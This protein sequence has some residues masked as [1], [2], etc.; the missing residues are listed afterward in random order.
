MQK[1]FD[2]G[3][4]ARRASLYLVVFLV[5]LVLFFPIYWMFN[6]S[7]APSTELFVYPPRLIHPNATFDAYR[8]VLTERP[9]IQWIGN[10]LYVV[11]LV[12][13][14]GLGLSLFGGYSLSRF[15]HRALTFAGWFFLISRMLPTS[16]LVI[17][18]F[19]MMRQ[20]G[21]IN[22]LHSLVLAN[23]VFIV[24][25]SIW[26]LKGYFDSIPFE[27]EEAAWL[28]G[29]SR[30]GALLRITLPLAA[31]GMAAT[32]LYG[33]IL[34]YSEYIFA[35]TFITGNSGWTIGLGLASFRGEYATNWNDVMAA[36]LIGALPIILIFLVA[37][38]YLIS[39]LTAGAA[40]S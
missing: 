27:L 2:L 29:C 10:S 7:L 32:A 36:S 22:S 28:D 16:L 19:L 20:L 23:L 5:C 31:P 1:T 25:F 34:T 11:V 30:T 14:A 40:K 26:M 33:A 38:R 37:E 17:P 6:T 39:G 35:R 24:P 21:L 8:K 4:V 15:R 3:H 12:T 13:V 9:L 18:L